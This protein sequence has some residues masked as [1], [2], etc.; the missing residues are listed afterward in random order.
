M[1]GSLNVD[2][3]PTGSSVIINGQAAGTTPLTMASVAPGTITV[4]IERPGYRPWTQTIELKA[5]ERRRV[6]AS[7]EIEQE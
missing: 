3:R 1:T 4:R 2:S 6:A 5:G 7:L